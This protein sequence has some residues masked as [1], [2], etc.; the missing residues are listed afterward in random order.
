MDLDV[1][2]R[3]SRKAS[4]A[5]SML[6]AEKR[7]RM[8]ANI[9][10]AL[11][12][13]SD[14]IIAENRKD[15]EEARKGGMRESM[16]DRL[17]LDENRLKGIAIG[18]DDVAKLDEVVDRELERIR[19][20]NGLEI[21]KRSVP[22]GVVAMIFESRPNV[23]VDMA[24]LCIKTANACV[25]KG[26]KEALNSNRALANVMR[27]AIGGIVDENVVTLIENN[28]REITDSLMKKKGMV[29]LLVPRGGKGL[30]NF[31]KENAKVPF[32]ETGAGNCHLYV[33][34]KADL[35]MAL[36]I[37]VNAK[38][39]R[40][41]VCNAIENI[42][43]DESAAKKFLPMLAS[44]F[45]RLSVEIRGDGESCGLIGC[46]RASDEDF[47]TEYDDRIVA[48]KIVSG[49][50][51]AIDFI[52]AHSTSHS[53]TIVTDDV[54]ARDE[55]MRRIDSACVYHNAS[56][57]FSDGGEFGFGAELGISTQKMH[58]RGPM[59]I[60]EMTSYKYFVYGEGQVRE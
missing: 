41:S 7:N 51:E 55:F 47:F 59:G 4:A 60:R 31:V 6:D 33:H 50:D 28:S 15:V 25:L 40:P 34:E 5:L 46:K 48:V 49:L 3:K 44:E 22:F 29:D 19:R 11:L 18:V 52:N 39:S 42:V 8:L 23:C 36:K 12:E 57:R 10:K 58:A 38:C 13:N 26:G 9:S 24:S 20:P 21:V 30:I 37:A 35:D 2:L 17:M 32:I 53:E 27:E 16:I 56:T 54:V 43:I 14:F 1:V 45:G